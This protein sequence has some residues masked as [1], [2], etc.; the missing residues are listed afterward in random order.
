MLGSAPMI[1]VQT[2]RSVETSPTVASASFGISQNDV[3]HILTMLRDTLYNDPGARRPARVRGECL[4]RA[5]RGWQ[6]RR[7]DSG[8]SAH[9]GSPDTGDSRLRHGHLAG[10]HAG[11]VSDG[12]GIDQAQQQHRRGT[13]GI[14]RLSGFAYGD[15]FV[16]ESRHAGVCSTYVAVIDAS[17]RGRIDLLDEQPATDTGLA[18]V[19]RF[20]RRISRVSA[21][22]RATIRVHAASPDDQRRASRMGARV[23]DGGSSG[24]RG[25]AG[26][27]SWAA[28]RIRSTCRRS[29]QRA[30]SHDLAGVLYFDIGELH[31]S[32]SR[33]ALKYTDQ[34]KRALKDKLDAFLDEY[35]RHQLAAIE[36]QATSPWDRRLRPCF[37]LNCLG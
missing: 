12:R 29:A 23:G 7:A 21:E 32:A 16:V 24:R 25:W 36:S 30:L 26:P 8:H 14:G 34:T 17:E 5:S 27:R 22:G 9:A 15:S 20:G 1:P 33:E 28:C 19:S 11:P 35:V 4:G 10:G 13:L 37:A 3:A 18:I 2:Q 6:G 31:F